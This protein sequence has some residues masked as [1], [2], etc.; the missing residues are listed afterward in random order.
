MSGKEL[1]PEISE[2][3]AFGLAEFRRKYIGLGFL[4]RKTVL[5]FINN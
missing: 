2:G 5:V 4:E 3:Q 1:L